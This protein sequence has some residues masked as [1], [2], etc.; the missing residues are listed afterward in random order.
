MPRPWDPQHRPRLLRRLKLWALFTGVG[1]LAHWLT[2]HS[3][4]A[5]PFLL[6][7]M[8]PLALALR[9]P[10]GWAL[11]SAVLVALPLAELRWLLLLLATT[12]AAAWLR[13]RPAPPMRWFSRFALLLSPLW[14]WLSWPRHGDLYDGLLAAATLLLSLAV[15][16]F[17]ALQ[18]NTQAQSPGSRE[19]RGLAE[20]LAS[21]LTVAAATP[22]CLIGAAM[23][24]AWEISDSGEHRREM[25]RR[26]GE[27]ALVA[28]SHVQQHLDA[29][30]LAAG[31]T[32]LPNRYPQLDRLQ[33]VYPGFLTLI[34]TDL[35]GNILRHH[36]PGMPA[37]VGQVADRSYFTEPRRNGRPY[38]SSVFR[39]RGF[40]NDVLVA[41]SAPHA[42]ANGAFAGVV[43]GSLSLA[44]LQ[45]RLQELAGRQQIDVVLLDPQHKVVVSSLPEHP[46]LSAADVD[47]LKPAEGAAG[48]YGNRPLSH[49]F[50]QTTVAPL[51][52]QALTLAP[53]APVLR[54]RTLA[55]AVLALGCLLIIIFLARST[56]RF[57]QPFA[58]PLG[59]L[60]ARIRTVDL[61]EPSSLTPLEVPAASAEFRELAADFNQMLIRLRELNDDLWRS[62]DSQAALNR[63]LEERVL[64]R[65]AALREAVARAEHLAEAKSMF[66]A[67]MSHELRTPLTAI[68]G[69][70]D[71]ALRGELPANRWQETLRTIARNG[72]H[73]LGVVNDVLD[74]SKIDAGQLQVER[75]AVSPVGQ[76][77]EAVRLLRERALQRGLELQVDYRWPLPEYLL[78][79]PLRLRQVLINLIGNAIKFTEQGMVMVRLQCD[80]PRWLQIRVIDSGIGM[81]EEQRAR[82]FRPFEQ[83]D[84]S[85]T[86]RFGGTGL[87]LYITGK[88]IEAMGG[89]IDVSSTAGVGSEFL[90]RLPLHDG[91]GS[92]D[93]VPETE[94]DDTELAVPILDGQVLVVDDVADLRLLVEQ[95]VR[96]TGAYTEGAQNGAQAVEMAQR[97]SFDLVLMDMHMPVLDGRAATRQLRAAGYRRPIVA[98]TADVLAEDVQRFIAAGC[99]EVLSKPVDRRRLYQTLQKHLRPAAGGAQRPSPDEA[100]AAAMASVRGRFLARLGDEIAALEGAQQRDDR[101]ALR[102]RLH[103]L[104]GSAGTFG[105]AAISELARLAEQALAENQVERPQRIAAL[106]AALRAAAATAE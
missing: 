39:G 94:Q 73:L 81:T 60:V 87:G 45:Q 53:L 44:T 30:R 46:P 57:V 6:G 77:E 47:A 88:L 19:Q 96:A 22:L 35:H 14:V 9:L 71:E 23:L 1:L 80:D 3:I 50:A 18:V 83:A 92:I 7:A 34:L 29:I 49:L 104:K 37:V 64:Q 74:A 17:G 31:E 54:E 10:L 68:L 59:D 16:Y 61:S 78:A 4:A 62:L 82:L 42:S 40:G 95:L 27:V 5:T 106:V 67:N 69:F 24:H 86:R 66:L 105:F 72:R 85:T 93:Q 90:V 102:S 21:S 12:L 11:S 43:E 84:L 25:A 55:S 48:R 75:I 51:G 76:V 41:V 100:L 38:V 98:L 26:A 20:Q 33:R 52:W 89:R 70:T 79:D 36:A 15:A 2:A 63:E 56:Q 99:N 8:A 101:D 28:S 13:R 32:I 97:G 58:A 65:T 103:R 91:F